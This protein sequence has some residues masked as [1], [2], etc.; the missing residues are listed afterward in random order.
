VFTG[1][2][3]LFSYYGARTK[4]KGTPGCLLLTASKLFFWLATLGFGVRL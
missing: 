4:E 3:K 2:Q 1:F